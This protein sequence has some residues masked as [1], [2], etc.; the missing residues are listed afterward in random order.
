MVSRQLFSVVSFGR[1]FD[2]H[3]AADALT[4]DELGQALTRF[5]LKLELAR[6][7]ERDL[8]RARHARDAFIRGQSAIGPMAKRFER[9]LG[10]HADSAD[11]GE[12]AA[13]ALADLEREIRREAKQDLRL[14]APALFAPGA[15]REDENV[16]HLSALVLDF[17]RGATPEVLR[18][19]F[20]DVFHL[21]HSTWSHTP[22]RPKLRLV[23]PLS[24]PVHP[25]DY[26]AIWHHADERTG[27]LADPTGRALARAWAL[28]AVPHPDRPRLAW[29]HHAP[30][31]DPFARGLAARPEPTPAPSPTHASLMRLDPGETY[32]PPNTTLEPHPQPSPTF[33]PWDGGA[34][35]P[36][37]PPPP[38]PVPTGRPQGPPL[39]HVTP[40]EPVPVPV[41]APV[42]APDPTPT[43]T[44]EPTPDP[45][46]PS[47]PDPPPPAPTLEAR[48]EALEARVKA[49]ESIL[50]DYL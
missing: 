35:S 12:R 32:L 47:T 26:A 43:P 22:E 39:H 15:R 16:V 1:V 4:L 50:A 38:A 28:P 20:A 8:E 14:W 37:P 21:A 27:K 3:P 45:P 23:I 36:A 30:L 25:D 41:P 19:L 11:P 7:E 34:P 2:V 18:D 29:T 42:P 5:Q 44:P 9:H 46:P 40:A 10:R 31:F 33:D 13:E 17:D 49:L 24:A 6:R 48:L